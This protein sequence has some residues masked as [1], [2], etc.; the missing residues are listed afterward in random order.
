[1]TCGSSKPVVGDER[2]NGLR[3]FYARLV[4]A[5]AEVA[6]GRIEDAFATVPRERFLGPGPWQV[7]VA[8][9]YIP[10]DTDDPGVLY[11]D[12]LIALLPDRGIN[13]G[14]P[15]LHA[16][17]LGAVAPKVGE[18]VI[19]VGAGTGY[20]TG[21]LAHL[22]GQSGKVHAFE[23]EP[24]LAQR[25]TENLAIYDAVTVH[26]T[27]ALQGPLAPADVI[28]VSAG[29]TRIPDAWIDV[30]KIGGRLVLPLTPTGGLGF[31]L[32]VHR[33][34][35]DRYAAR[36]VSPA[37]FVPCI[38]E[39]DESESQALIQALETRTPEAIRSLRRRSLPDETAWCAGHGWWLSTVDA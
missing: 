12:I 16:K 38:G 39:N 34:G 36:S 32:L 14:E 25:A 11:Q 7:R 20:Y 22:V 3:R 31:M 4:T 10:T 17:C 13:N 21:I 2:L 6:D 19:H 37:A 5:I 29:V 33:V 23:V 28:Y 18:T 9:R 30:L 27:S 15:S 24:E 35:S 26:R 8:G 1:M